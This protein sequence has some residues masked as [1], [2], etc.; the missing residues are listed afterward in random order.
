MGFMSKERIRHIRAF[1]DSLYRMVDTNPTGAVERA[2]SFKATEHLRQSEVDAIKCTM[3]SA[4]FTSLDEERRKAI[5]L[6]PWDLVVFD[7]AHHARR[8]L[9]SEA[10]LK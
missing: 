5:A 2:R 3:T 1:A 6:V 8:T 7:E 4:S 10:T 9:N